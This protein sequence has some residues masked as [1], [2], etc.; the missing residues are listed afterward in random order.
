MKSC[1][2]CGNTIAKEIETF[3]SEYGHD[4]PLTDCRE[5]EGRS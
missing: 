5:S 1:V 4:E 3:G 2:M